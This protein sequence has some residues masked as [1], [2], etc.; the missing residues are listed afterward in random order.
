M[1]GSSPVET[2]VD[3]IAEIEKLFTYSQLL[4]WNWKLFN[5]KFVRMFEHLCVRVLSVLDLKRA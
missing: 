3:C 1:G 5:L 4:S 2:F